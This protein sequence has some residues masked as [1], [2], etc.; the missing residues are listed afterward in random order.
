[1]VEI[2]AGL[3]EHAQVLLAEPDNGAK[4]PAEIVKG[5]EDKIFVD[6][7]MD[8]LSAGSIS[9]GAGGVAVC[10]EAPHPEPATAV[11]LG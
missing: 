11:G 2:K 5:V 4:I 9:I 1:M 8:L 6:L 3:D 7:S 10:V